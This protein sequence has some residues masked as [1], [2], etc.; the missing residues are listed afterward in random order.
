[1]INNSNNDSS[2]N[3]NMYIYKTPFIAGARP[4]VAARERRPP[5]RGDPFHVAAKGYVVLVIVLV[6]VLSLLL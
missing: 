6:P 5:L 2:N 3:N 4:F 1:M